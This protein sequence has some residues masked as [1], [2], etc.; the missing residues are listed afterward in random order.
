M[1]RMKLVV[2]SQP[3]VPHLSMLDQLPSDVDVTVGLTEEELAR[4]IADADAVFNGMGKGD[5]LKKVLP[6]A[7]SVRWI[8]SMSAGVE[9]LMFPEMVQSPVPLTNARGV[10]AESLGEFVIAGALY[11]AKDFPRM[12]RAQV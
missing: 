6:H 3:N 9:H 8:H 5:V 10:F 7:K 2:I 11:F 12:R 4:P 1:P